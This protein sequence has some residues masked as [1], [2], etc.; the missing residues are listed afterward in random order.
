MAFM[1][2]QTTFGIGTNMATNTSA[3]DTSIADS[4]KT[5]KTENPKSQEWPCASVPMVRTFR[6]TEVSDIWH[7]RG[8]SLCRRPLLKRRR[9][10]IRDYGHEIPRT[11]VYRTSSYLSGRTSRASTITAASVQ[12]CTEHLA[13]QL[14]PGETHDSGCARSEWDASRV[15]GLTSVAPKALCNR[16]SR[17][18]ARV[19]P[20]R[21]RHWRCNACLLSSS[22]ARLHFTPEHAHR[23]QDASD[24][25]S[26]RLGAVAQGREPMNWQPDEMA[27]GVLFRE[28]SMVL[29][30]HASRC[31]SQTPALS[32]SGGR[33]PTCCH[34]SMRG[35]AKLQ[36]IV[37]NEAS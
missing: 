22:R 26:H 35:S 5:E 1:R 18:C 20:T 11:L 17:V 10:R 36:S 2:Q 25:S 21:N 31:G 32:R 3:Q 12:R 8:E 7:V 19:R 23:S 33:G 37:I 4:V 24:N 16:G 34:C 27:V 14:D 9:K 13:S 28:M 29:D 6:Q 30:C 15:R